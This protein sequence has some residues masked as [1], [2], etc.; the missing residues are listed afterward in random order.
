MA[1]TSEGEAPLYRLYWDRGSANM[2]PHAL[3]R[4][5]GVPFDLVHV[6][7]ASGAHRAP[8]Y[9]AL[10]PNQRVPT[11]V[12]GDMV[13][14]ES[15]AILLYLCESHPEASLMPL[16]GDPRRHLFLQWLFYFTN[17]LQEDLQHW[18]HADNYVTAEACRSDMKAVAEQRLG[19]FFS[20]F[21]SSLAKDGPYVL[22]AR[23]SACD[24]FFVM[25]CR[26]TRQMPVTARD[27][28]NIRRLV[29]LV[30]QRPAWRAMMAAEGI[31]WSGPLT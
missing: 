27:Y 30:T 25:L 13:L 2:A 16:P 15:A 20:R 12:H 6:D 4:E 26:W 7:V 18:W 14:Y 22:G 17:T 28:P 19:R 11:L 8:G 5:L 9:T 1:A 24:L 23:F 29:D 21:D 31:N 3:L 10:N